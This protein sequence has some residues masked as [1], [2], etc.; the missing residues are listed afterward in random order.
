VVAECKPG[1][2]GRLAVASIIFDLDGVLIDSGGDIANAANYT[3]EALGM[4]P[5]PK[6]LVASYVGGGAESILRL[7]LGP[8]SPEL[9]ERALPIFKERYAERCLVETTL[10][11]GVREVL[12]GCQARG[13]PMGIATNKIERVTLRILEGTGIAGYFAAVV[14]PERVAH[15]KPDPEALQIIMTEIG[16]A[17]ATTLMVGDSPNDILAGRNAGCQ[18]CGVTYG[19]GTA[20]EIGAARPDVIIDEA[21]RLL[22]HLEP[23]G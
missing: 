1:S 2:P 20:R 6:A 21:V 3:L 17:P 22:D 12:A 10:Y 15:R 4:S 7:C 19:V 9:F 23:H 8:G 14:G 16:A 11:P 13:I 18:T 5:L